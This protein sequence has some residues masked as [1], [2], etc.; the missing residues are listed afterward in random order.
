MSR[1]RSSR[2]KEPCMCGARDCP[3]CYPF[4]WRQHAHEPEDNEELERE[5]YEPEP[6]DE[7]N[8]YYDPYEPL[9]ERQERGM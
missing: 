4:D 9:T 7:P 2:Y 8:E 1:T 6:P 5:E 3:R